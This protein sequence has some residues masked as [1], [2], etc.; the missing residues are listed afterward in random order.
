MDRPDTPHTLLTLCGTA[1]WGLSSAARRATGRCSGI[2]CASTEVKRTGCLW[3]TD[4]SL[5]EP[6]CG[7]GRLGRKRSVADEYSTWIH[8]RAQ[9][10]VLANTKYECGV[11]EKIPTCA[12]RV[13]SPMFCGCINGRLAV[14]L[15]KVE[16]KPKAYPTTTRGIFFFFL[17]VTFSFLSV[18]L[19]QGAEC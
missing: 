9:R 4:G 8:H 11:R 1:F 2:K 14:L 7:A 3:H 18:G 5:G 17:Q 19:I 16:R 12:R 6:G 10:A 13:P 15:I